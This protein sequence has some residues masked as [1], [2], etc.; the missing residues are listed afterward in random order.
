MKQN[1]RNSKCNESSYPHESIPLPGRLRAR[2]LNQIQETNMDT[3]KLSKNLRTLVDVEPDKSPFI[4]CYL[5]LD[6][7]RPNVLADVEERMEAARLSLRGQARNDFDDALA[8]VRE[9]AEKNLVPKSRGAAFFSRSG[10]SPFFLTMQFDVPLPSLLVVDDLPHV[11]PLAEIKDRFHRFVIVL[12][13]AQE[14]RIM[15]VNIGAIMEAIVAERPDLRRRMGREWTR[16]HYQNHRRDRE[17][18]FLQEK[19]R[20]LDELVRE[21]EHAHIILAGQSAYVKQMERAL[22]PRLAAKVL[23]TLVCDPRDGVSSILRDALQVFAEAE[24]EESLGYVRRLEG[25]V[26]S[27][28][29]GVVGYEACRQALEYG[30]ADR[31]LVLED[32][33][34]LA[35]REELTRLALQTG[36]EVETVADCP[37]LAAFGG[38]GCLLRFLVPGPSAESRAA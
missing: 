21:G 7:A 26:R 5:N 17:E 3:N 2:F 27:G 8:Q 14:A 32:S 10:D 38:A 19:V 18:R 9:Y 13:T 31:L 30:Q 22:P 15:E 34:D 16:E 23:N 4:S 24:Q 28:G 6:Q 36:V 29:L 37:V 1:P 25:A 33:E 35:Q 12:T 11:Y 20:L